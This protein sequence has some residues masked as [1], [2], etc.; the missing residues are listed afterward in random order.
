MERYTA[1]DP[2]AE[3]GSGS[4]RG[5]GEDASAERVGPVAIER[6]RKDDGRAL[7]LYQRIGAQ[8]P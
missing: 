4:C 6:L 1:A 8:E 7:I 3:R 5:V 2:A